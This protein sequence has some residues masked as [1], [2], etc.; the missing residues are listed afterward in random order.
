MKLLLQQVRMHIDTFLDYYGFYI[1]GVELVG[2]QTCVQVLLLLKDS[3]DFVRVI[4]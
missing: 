3:L 1:Y 4:L 2:R